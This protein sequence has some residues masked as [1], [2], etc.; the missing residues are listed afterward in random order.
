MPLFIT[1][2]SYSQ[3]GIKGLIAQPDDRATAIEK[4]VAAANIRI[5]ALYMTTG[6]HDAVL[7]TEAPDAEAAVAI[8]MAAAASGSVSSVRTVQAWTSTEFS[9]I[10]AK[11]GGLTGAYTSPGG[12]VP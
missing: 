5:V 1:F 12:F 6:E 7:I 2:V 8:G 3:S 10:A 9:A 4:M 11:A